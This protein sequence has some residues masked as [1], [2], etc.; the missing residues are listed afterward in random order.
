MK[1][2]RIQISCSRQ[3]V[4]AFPFAFQ[5]THSSKIDKDN[6]NCLY[7]NVFIWEISILKINI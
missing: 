3:P 7:I 6:W 2:N 1:K 4:F 5:I